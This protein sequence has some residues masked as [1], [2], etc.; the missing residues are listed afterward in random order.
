MRRIA[1]A[2]ANCRLGAP[3]FYFKEV[4]S[5]NDV[6]REKAVA[7]APEGCVVIAGAQTAGRGRRGRQWL[8]VPDKG[9]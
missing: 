9:V 8:S 5:T 2:L 3:L 7:G 4:S 1:S 6:L